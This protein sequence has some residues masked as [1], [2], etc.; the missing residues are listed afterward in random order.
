MGLGDL[1]RAHQGWPQKPLSTVP[2]PER[3]KGR[4]DLVAAGW[5]HPHVWHLGWED[6]DAEHSWDCGLEHPHVASIDA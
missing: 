1:D 3:L 6:S 5:N 2:Q 4:D